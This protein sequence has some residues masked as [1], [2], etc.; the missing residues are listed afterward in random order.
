MLKDDASVQNYYAY[1]LYGETTPSTNDDGNSSEYTG[2]DN[3]ST[4]VY[5]YRARYFDPMLKRFISADPIGIAGGLNLY[6]YVGGDP[7]SWVDPLGL[8]HYNAPAPQTVPVTGAT[9]TKLQCVETCLQ[10]ATDNPKLDLLIT[11]GTEKKGHSRKSHHKKNEACDIAG[12]K[13]NAVS[14]EDV[15]ECAI[16]CGFGAGQF[17]IFPGKPKRNHWHLQITPGNGVP[18]LKRTTPALPILIPTT[19]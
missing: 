2:R 13:F 8:L 15:R 10:V 16:Q 6:A 1:S 11:G 9:A 14:N 18:A 3:D 17:E 7:L 5:Y 19:A 4:G 12:P